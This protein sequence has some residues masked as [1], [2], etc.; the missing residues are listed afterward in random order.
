MD[1]ELDVDKMDYL[2]R[3]SQY[4]GVNYGTFDLDRLITA[5]IVTLSYIEGYP[6]VRYVPSVLMSK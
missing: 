2:L 6:I 1:S 5:V 4:C 3:D